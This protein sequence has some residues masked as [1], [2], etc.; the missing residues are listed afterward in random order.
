MYYPI[1]SMIERE[2]RPGRV[3]RLVSPGDSIEVTH[4]GQYFETT[5]V[6]TDIGEIVLFGLHGG[7]ELEV[8]D[9]VTVHEGKLIED[10]CKKL[11]EDQGL[12]YIGVEMRQG[13]PFWPNNALFCRLDI[14]GINKS[15]ETELL[16]HKDNDDPTPISA[17]DSFWRSTDPNDTK[18]YAIFASPEDKALLS[19]FGFS[20]YTKPAVK[21]TLF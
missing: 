15:F 6:R 7:T 3:V 1:L 17:W 12:F 8:F 11:E 5:P 4:G 13:N 9:G 21:P 18:E 20:I 19:R 10:T 2:A 14:E 16:S